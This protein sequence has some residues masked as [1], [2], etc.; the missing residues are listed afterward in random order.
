MLQVFTTDT[1]TELPTATA[2]FIADHIAN[3]RR[4]LLVEGKHMPA[5]KPY[6][7]ARHRALAKGQKKPC[8]PK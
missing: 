1:M 8:Q 3:L 6:S 2:N 5:S 4:A 7:P